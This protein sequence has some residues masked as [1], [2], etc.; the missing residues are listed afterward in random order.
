MTDGRAYCDHTAAGEIVE[1]RT[2]LLAL[3]KHKRLTFSS[4]TQTTTVFKKK[5]KVFLRF[6]NL[7][8]TVSALAY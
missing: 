5:R 6:L 1:L 8:E 2:L 4:N 7:Q 3:S